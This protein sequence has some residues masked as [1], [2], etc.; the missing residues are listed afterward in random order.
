MEGYAE[1]ANSPILWGITALAI[2]LVLIQSY[3]I[4]KKSIKAGQEMGISNDK[5]KSAFKT[6]LIT[7]VGPTGVIVIGMVSLLVVVG[8]PT[9]LMRLAYIG[10]VAYELLAVQFAAEATGASLTDAVLS[11]EV[12]AIALW[13]MSIGCIGWIVFTAIATDKMG[14]ITDKFSGSSAKTFSAVSIGAML[15]AYAYLNA[16]Y[17]TSMDANT[18]AMI[19]GGIVMFIVLMAYKKTKK[20]WINEWSL[21]IA[22]VVGMIIAAVL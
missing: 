2:G 13:C 7:S 11:P 18:V 9:A 3:L 17:A 15:G 14:K 8:G 5:M 21:T 12:F 1:I 10:N 6:G 4:M 19:V 22:M 20:K 16:G